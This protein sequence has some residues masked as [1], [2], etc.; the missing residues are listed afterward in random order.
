MTTYQQ[1]K[2]EQTRASK[3]A[4]AQ[5]RA[6]KLRTK[7]SK[8]QTE[9]QTELQTK[10]TFSPLMYFCSFITYSFP[11]LRSTSVRTL[12]HFCSLY[13][14]LEMELHS[15]FSLT[16]LIW[17]TT[18]TLLHFLRAESTQPPF[19]CDSADPSTKSYPFCETSLPVL[20][21]ARDLVSRLTLDEKVSQLINTAPAVPRL[22]VPA[23]QW[24]SEALHG[25]VDGNGI[26]F[27]GNI[28]S[29]TSFP[30]VILTGATFDALLWYRIG[31]AIGREARA[32]YNE[33]QAKGMTFWAPNINVYRDP[34][35]GRGQETPGEDP[36]VAGKYA[37]SF[38]RG[39]QGDNFE[40]GGQRQG[41]LQASACCKHFT[42]Y[43][44]DNWKGI[45]R[46]GFNA[47]VTKQDMADTYQPPFQS[48]VQ[49]GRASGIMCAYNQVNGVPNCADYN[50]LS[51]TARGQWG[52]QGYITS[53]CDAVSIIHDNQGYAK[54]PEDAVSDV[55][56]AGILKHPFT[57]IYL[58]QYQETISFL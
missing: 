38:V 22:G 4:A 19:S 55:L 23:Y 15:N 33:G 16:N 27:D 18:L 31:K 24:W 5:T 28:R 37:V 42:A 26:R 53:D 8:L 57:F 30:Q 56:K 43:D 36:L 48:C 45:N 3:V 20:L 32:V 46:F 58:T 49:K 35:W 17:V 39:I 34:R 7:A 51:K 2:P 11:T 52:F 21:R 12:P 50:L 9:L 1:H 13:N 41:H 25:V 44:L 29:A 14:Q 6:S 54:S 10:A 47:I 40:G